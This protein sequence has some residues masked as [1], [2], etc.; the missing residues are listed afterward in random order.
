M[1]QVH[2]LQAAL[3]DLAR[4]WLDARAHDRPA[5]TG[6]ARTI[7]EILRANPE[8]EGESRSGDER[9]TFVS[10]LG[11]EFEVD[12]DQRVVWILHVWQFTRRSHS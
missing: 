9:V 11:L 7:D 1:F 3:D 5:V 10:P 8:Q 6:A 4:I 12:S 2:W